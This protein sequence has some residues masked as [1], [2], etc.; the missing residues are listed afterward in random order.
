MSEHKLDRERPQRFIVPEK[1]KHPLGWACQNC[2]HVVKDTT[3]NS[4]AMKCC[5]YPPSPQ[6]AQ[7]QG[8]VAQVMAMAPPVQLD[9]WCGEYAP[10]V[11]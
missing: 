1:P 3:P 9:E 11:A 4:R 10:L 8:G 2:F 5:R 7:L 6:F